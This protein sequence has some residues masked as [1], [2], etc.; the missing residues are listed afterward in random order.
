MARG[1]QSLGSVSQSCFSWAAAC[2]A[3]AVARALP[4]PR[5]PKVR[6]ATTLVERNM[7]GSGE[8]ESTGAIEEVNARWKWLMPNNL[9]GRGQES[10][11]KL[12]LLPGAAD[13]ATAP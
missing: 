6:N 9:Q 2:W 4:H 13:L 3:E 12:T 8:S 5:R 7:A 11:R 1:Y 10:G